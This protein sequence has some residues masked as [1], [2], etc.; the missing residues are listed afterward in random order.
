MP[1]CTIEEAWSQSINPDLQSQ[2]FKPNTNN[3]YPDDYSNIELEQS[4]LYNKKGNKVN[5]LKKKKKKPQSRIS[6]LSRTYDRL[7]EHSGNTS[8]FKENNNGSKRLVINNKKV[9][10]D[11]SEKYPNYMNSDLPI[12]EY[13]NKLYQNL[14]DLE[15]ADSEIDDVNEES[16]TENES[17]EEFKS[18]ENYDNNRNEFQKLKKE[19]LELKDLIRELKENKIDNNDSMLDILV[20]VFSGVMIILMMENITRLYRKT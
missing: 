17:T 15:R 20:F 19:N 10:I 4:E 7:S 1:Y 9:N 18:N 3:N 16:F 2:D 5:F 14:D 11:N 8:R 13:N 6:N 12:N